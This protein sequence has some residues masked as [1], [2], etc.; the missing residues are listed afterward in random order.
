MFKSKK[1]QG[2]SLNYVVIGVIGIVIV[3]VIIMIF[4]LGMKRNI[5]TLENTKESAITLKKCKEWAEKEDIVNLCGKC[6]NFKTWIDEYDKLCSSYVD[7]N[8]DVNEFKE[9]VTPKP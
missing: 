9:L 8:I 2:L 4:T 6:S 7:S 3:V 5:N 1:S